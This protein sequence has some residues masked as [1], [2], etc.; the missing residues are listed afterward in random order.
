MLE[1]T[2]KKS[3]REIINTSKMYS[4]VVALIGTATSVGGVG[5]AAENGGGGVAGGTGADDAGTGEDAG[6]TSGGTGDASR[7][8][9][10]TGTDRSSVQ[11]PV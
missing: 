4:D 8:S 9:A 10:M 1:G 3:Q 11:D 2:F 5:P 6:D 7:G